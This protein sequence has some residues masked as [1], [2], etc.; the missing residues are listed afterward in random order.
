MSKSYDLSTS[1]KWANLADGDH[2]VKLRARGAG[3]GSSSFSNSVTVTKGSAMPVKGDLITI[4]SKQYRVL[5]TNGSVA[6]VLAMYDASTPIKFDIDGTN[7][8]SGKTL[9]NYCNSTFYSDLPESM[10]S[11]IVDKTFTQD[12]WE[13]FSNAPTGPHYTG[14]DKDNDLYYYYISD[15]EFGASITRHCYC[16]SI[17]D[18][19]DYLNCTTSMSASNT[20]LI[21]TN[22]FQMF[23]N[24]NVSPGNK[25]IWLRSAQSGTSGSAYCAS[26]DYGFLGANIATNGRT[27]RPAFQID[28]SKIEWSPVGGVTEHTLTFSNLDSLTVN[29]STVTSPYTLQNGD[30]I[31]A[32]KE[33]ITGDTPLDIWI[34][35][36]DIECTPSTNISEVTGGY[37]VQNADI[38]ITGQL[39]KYPEGDAQTRTV[40]ITYKTA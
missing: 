39:E 16:L 33:G 10:K 14:K 19:L 5:K 36:I 1:T 20:T 25:F 26:G 38:V 40:Q 32:T 11:A 29:G 15:N 2:V 9:D 3:Y 4:E 35:S 6:E 12:S 13:A 31:V 34:A 18:V 22:I 21:G 17:Q 24:V 27:A 7:S 28:L 30:V 37:V 8:Y 23:W